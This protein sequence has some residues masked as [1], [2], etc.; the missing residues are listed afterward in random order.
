MCGKAVKIYYRAA[1]YEGVG[2][3]SI[4]GGE[5]AEDSRFE[6]SGT[7]NLELRTSLRAFL[8]EDFPLRLKPVIKGALADTLFVD[9]AGSRRDPC[10][11]IFRHGRRG[12]IGLRA[13]SRFLARRLRCGRF[14]QF[15]GFHPL[16]PIL[17]QIRAA[18]LS[19]PQGG[20][21]DRVDDVVVAFVLTRTW[22]MNLVTRHVRPKPRH[23][24]RYSTTLGRP[25][26]HVRA[27]R[28]GGLGG[29]QQR[30]RVNGWSQWKRQPRA[31]R[32][33]PICG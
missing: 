14:L 24:R 25:N 1:L 15:L 8:C 6:V 17:N 22:F 5:R 31:D 12:R 9:L 28:E 26:A 32:L 4:K 30:S 21:K 18:R 27:G 20:V 2:G 13:A 23:S 29:A 3:E 11:E 16:S 19:R 33:L 7:S 10:V